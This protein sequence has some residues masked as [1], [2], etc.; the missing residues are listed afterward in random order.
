MMDWI[1]WVCVPWQ[2]AVRA[3]AT[4]RIR[5]VV[6]GRRPELTA[7]KHTHKRKHR[8]RTERH[9]STSRA[10]FEAAEEE[11]ERERAYQVLHIVLTHRHNNFS[12]RLIRPTPYSP[13]HSTK[14]SVEHHTPKQERR[15]GAKGGGVG[16][17]QG[18]RE[19][20]GRRPTTGHSTSRLHRS[21]CKTHYKQHNITHRIRYEYDSD[22]LPCNTT[23][24]QG[25][26]TRRPAPALQWFA[27]HSCRR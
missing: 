25:R 19:W 11:E 22:E 20:R 14:R 16:R 4:E 10:T 5:R 8:K 1:G 17:Y 6:P 7:H 3:Q 12:A 15:K 26:G 2:I 24:R 21:N 23:Q 13:A 9:H 18:L 27:R